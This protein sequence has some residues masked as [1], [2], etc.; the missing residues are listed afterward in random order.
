[1]WLTP[2]GSS[3]KELSVV[4][5]IDAGLVSPGTDAYWKGILA[6]SHERQPVQRLALAAGKRYLDVLAGA[7]YGHGQLEVMWGGRK[8][9]DGHAPFRARW[10]GDAYT[11][12]DSLR[13]T[14]MPLDEAEK[15]RKEK[16]AGVN[17]D[18]RYGHDVMAEFVAARKLS[19][20]AL[21][22]GDIRINALGLTE[23]FAALDLRARGR[24][25]APALHLVEQP[26]LATPVRTL[27][28]VSQQAASRALGITGGVT[29]SA[30][31][32][33]AQGSCRVVFGACPAQG[34]PGLS[35]KTGTSDFLEREDGTDAKQG[36]QL[37]AK[38]FGGV[39]TGADGK[40]YAVAVMALRVRQTGT[41]TL[42]LQSSAPAE[43]ALT[44]MR[45]MGVR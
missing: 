27:S 24:T 37:P 16:L 5:G 25:Q 42:E 29:A 26:G 41:A 6:E 2:P 4:A 31:K 11:G 30:W 8:A 19:D 36:L 10:S 7:G 34:L 38:L 12:T 13:A 32:G 44:L 1:M 28:W 18:K 39:F 17:V 33:T 23:I 21:G 20:A 3:L 22:G 14:S 45:E 35:G 15:I 40:R 43:A 9:D